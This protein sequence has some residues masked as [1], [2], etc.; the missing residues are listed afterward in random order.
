[1][2][3]ALYTVETWCGKVGLS[4]NPDKTD[5]VIF[6]RKRKFSAF[7]EPLFFGG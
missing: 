5:L 2:V 7:T 4:V 3:L 6:K 1:M